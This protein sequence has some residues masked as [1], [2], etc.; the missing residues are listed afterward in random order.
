MCSK[1]RA[2]RWIWFL[3]VGRIQY[4]LYPDDAVAAISSVYIPL[5]RAYYELSVQTFN[6]HK[7]KYGK[8][9]SEKGK[10]LNDHCQNIGLNWRGHHCFLLQIWN[11]STIG[12]HDS[13]WIEWFSLLIRRGKVKLLWWLVCKSHQCVK[14]KGQ[15]HHGRGCFCK[16]LYSLLMVYGNN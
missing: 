5:W 2:S 7:T 14:S 1:K 8:K 3:Y 10:F 11:L 9:I 12:I 4:T 15:S 16:Y 13:V 6:F